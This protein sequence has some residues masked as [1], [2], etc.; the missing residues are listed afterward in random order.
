M[1]NLNFSISFSAYWA[2]LPPELNHKLGMFLPMASCLW[3]C[4]GM[5]DTLEFSNPWPGIKLWR[6]RFGRAG[7]RVR[8]A[9]RT[10]LFHSLCWWFETKGRFGAWPAFALACSKPSYCCCCRCLPRSPR[11]PSIH[12]LLLPSS[13][14]RQ[15]ASGAFCQGSG[16]NNVVWGVCL[17]WGHVGCFGSWLV[18]Q[19]VLCAAFML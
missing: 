15:P 4:H 16:Q 9:A 1:A 14:Q 5:T 12:P 11:V 13:S 10:S 8:S 3:L 6:E 2:F 17:S 19:P 7:A 18:M